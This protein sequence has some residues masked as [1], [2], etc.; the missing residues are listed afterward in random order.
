MPAPPINTVLPALL[1]TVS[2]GDNSILLAAPG[3]GKTTRVPLALLEVVPEHAGRILLVEP[4]RLAAVAAAR[5]MSR[6]VG[7]EVGRTV[8]YTIRFES[9]ASVATRIEVVTEGILLRRLQNDPL[10]SGVAMILFDEYHERSL[11]ADLAL[12]LALDVQRTV[13]PELKLLVMSATLEAEPLS[14]LLGEAQI[15]AAPGNSFPVREIFLDDHGDHVRGLPQ[16]VAAAVAR[17]MRECDGDIL[18]FLPGTAEIRV[19]A[20]LLQAAAWCAKDVIVQQLYGDLP[21]DRQQEILQPGSRRRVILATNIAETSLTIEEIS[22]VIDSGLSR[23]M[24]FDHSRGMNRLVTR[25]ESRSS[26]VQRGG[27]AGRTG[28]GTCYRLFSRHTFL[29]MTPQTL[30][31]ILDTDLSGML[32]ELAAWGCAD[33][34]AYSWLDPP[35]ASSIAVARNLLQSLGAL[36]RTGRITPTGRRM[37]DIPLHPRLSR[38]LIMSGDLGCPACG[39]DL[40]ALLSER[41]VL[42]HDSSVRMSDVTERLKALAA[43]RRGGGIAGYDR[44]ALRAVDRV[45]V[46]LSGIVSADRGNTDRCTSLSPVA[47]LLLAAFPDRVARQRDSDPGRYL[48]ANG[49]GAV[50]HHADG[51]ASSSLLVIPMLTAGTTG[52][53]VIRLAVDVSIE[54]IRTVHRESIVTESQV[55]WDSREGRITAVEEER[56]GEIVLSRRMVPSDRRMEGEVILEALRSSSLALL[57]LDDRFRQ[58]QCRIMLLRE[59]MPEGEWPDVSDTALAH[60]LDVWLLP[61]LSGVRSVQQLAAVDCSAALSAT[62]GY[63]QRKE[64]DELAPTHIHVPS[65]SRIRLDYCS[66]NVPV[67]AVKLQELFGLAESPVIARGRMRVLLHLLSPAGRALQVTTDLKGFWDGS[68]HQVKKEMKGRYPRHPWPDDPWNALPTRRTKGK[69]V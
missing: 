69:P 38:M 22:V 39:A 13:R 19:C 55:K 52:D 5:W 31:E 68:Y 54:E 24:Q 62:L 49:S 30:P 61:Y 21:F 3:A 2:T 8:G 10:L 65:G 27:R 35:P 12:A 57:A 15:V 6:L 40:A 11:Q 32:L 14:K 34:A 9:R 7:D 25:R 36:D 50:F 53:A 44:Q 51:L 64:L 16:R 46:Q 48:M 60:S 18:V 20:D 23:R 59:V 43:W 4:R 45:A 67:L 28:P 42:L 56:L 47:M 37:A 29:A 33:P 63:Q 1:S 41:D 58:L 26:A 66:G 17:A